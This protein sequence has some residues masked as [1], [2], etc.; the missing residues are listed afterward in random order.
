MEKEGLAVVEA[1]KVFR[2]YLKGRQFTIVTDHHTLKFL[3]G[4]D[5]STRRLAR[6]FDTLRDMDFTIRYRLRFANGN[7][8]APPIFSKWG[9]SPPIFLSLNL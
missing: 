6:W 2:P 7:A 5:P 9:Q 3:A 8:G 1:C 4:K